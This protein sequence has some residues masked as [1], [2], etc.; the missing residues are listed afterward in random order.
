MSLRSRLRVVLP[1]DGTIIAFVIVYII[2]EAPYFYLERQIGQPLDLFRPSIL[3]LR[4]AALY[5]G[6]WRVMA[7][8]PVDRP[9]YRTWLERTPWTWRKPLPA[10]DVRLGWVDLLPIAA[11]VSAAA[12]RG[13]P[14][15]LTVVSLVLFGY[16]AAA[17]QVCWYTRQTLLGFAVAFGIGAGIRLWPRPEWCLTALAITY[18]VAWLGIELGLSQ[19]PW[20]W[21]P[22]MELN[23]TNAAAEVLEKSCG[24]PFDQLA[25][26]AETTRTVST[27]DG[28][29]T[30]L[31]VGWLLFCVEGLFPNPGLRQVM[32]DIAHGC[33]LVFL[34][35][36]RTLTYV[37]GYP[38]PIS[39][40]G[41][42]RTGRWIIPRYDQ[43][44]LAP[45]CTALVGVL[46]TD[47]FRPGNL[48]DDIWMPIGVAMGVMITLTTPP[49][50]AQ[51]RLTGEH[52]IIP[53]AN[54]K[55]AQGYVKVG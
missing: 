41:R 26:A 20:P 49:T 2:V 37:V 24:W 3:V 34:V 22:K 48:G 12:P 13:V 54:Q 23:P 45:L 7:F 10:G 38:P 25:P 8:H 4:F 31:L 53:T 16:L 27:R 19:F 14:V 55:S 36:G 32:L 5:Y 52:R 47:R 50:L 6:V 29:L 17:A 9:D 15:C 21:L 39:L 42:I 30:G 18:L 43:V 46:A 44:F 1:P 51:W 40:L 11:I 33:I 28:I 35:I